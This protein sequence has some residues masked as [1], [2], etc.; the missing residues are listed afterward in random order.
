MGA[1]PQRVK[2]RGIVC[3]EIRINI[4]C[5]ATIRNTFPYWVEL[6]KL[7][8]LHELVHCERDNI[9]STVFQLQT[10]FVRFVVHLS[11]TYGRLFLKVAYLSLTILRHRRLVAAC[12]LK[13][14]RLVVLLSVLCLLQVYDKSNR[15]CL[16]NIKSMYCRAFKCRLSITWR[17]YL[18]RHCSCCMPALPGSMHV[19]VEHMHYALLH[20]GWPESAKSVKGTGTQ[21]QNADG[22]R[23][24]SLTHLVLVGFSLSFVVRVMR[25]YFRS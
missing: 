1:R 4:I 15:C 22:S 21:P 20:V 5:P 6:F 3:I 8:K 16:T 24:D 18:C 10:P 2:V 25:V 7:F 13:S 14:R 11:V 17:G 12:L 9:H 23:A 19:L